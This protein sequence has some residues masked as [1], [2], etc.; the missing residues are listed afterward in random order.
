M[1]YCPPGQRS[2][3]TPP[4]PICAKVGVNEGGGGSGGG[5]L[6]QNMLNLVGVI[7]RILV[8]LGDGQLEMG[9]TSVSSDS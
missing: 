5:V 8:H 1:N 7:S 2:I 3:K 4:P 9:S 6:P